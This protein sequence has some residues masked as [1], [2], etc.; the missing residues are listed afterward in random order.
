MRN[1]GKQLHST[2]VG[3]IQRGGQGWSGY[4]ISH[5]LFSKGGVVTW[6]FCYYM[7]CLGNMVRSTVSPYV[8]RN[9]MYMYI[10]PLLT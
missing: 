1:T 6:Q 5:V 3:C 8:C 4:E 9:Y 10:Q 2:C 7:L